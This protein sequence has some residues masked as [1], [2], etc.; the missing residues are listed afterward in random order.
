[1]TTNWALYYFGKFSQRWKSMIDM[2][3]PARRAADRAGKRSGAPLAMPRPPWCDRLKFAGECGD[4][5]PCRARRSTREYRLRKA[6]RFVPT[7]PLGRP[8]E[9]CDDE[10]IARE[11][12]DWRVDRQGR[13][14][15]RKVVRAT[16]SPA[17]F[18]H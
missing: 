9:P 13:K 8:I 15:R 5:Q 6:G 11:R 14:Q 10:G 17:A 1:M 12:R 18:R 7:R 16:P 2:R 3:L 4:C